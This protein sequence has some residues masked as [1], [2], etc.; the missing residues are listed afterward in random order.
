[1]AMAVHNYW[2]SP[3]G[4]PWIVVL[5]LKRLS[6]EYINI[7]YEDP[8]QIIQIPDLQYPYC[9]GT[10]RYRVPSTRGL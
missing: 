6:M 4:Q 3:W 5:K 8:Q 10:T 9:T 2:H 1:M 7:L